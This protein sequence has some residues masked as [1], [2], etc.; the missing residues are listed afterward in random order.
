[1]SNQEI[2]EKAIQEA[3]TNGFMPEYKFSFSKDMGWTYVLR[4]K[5]EQTKGGMVVNVTGMLSEGDIIFGHDF[6]KALWGEEDT[7]Y[8]TWSNR[9]YSAGGGGPDED[10]YDGQLW[11]FHLQQMVIAEDPV[12]YLG[13]NL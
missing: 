8:D 7:P 9:K 13:E 12:Q 5:P 11:E 6:A 1:M 4:E 10:W 2:L 3:Q